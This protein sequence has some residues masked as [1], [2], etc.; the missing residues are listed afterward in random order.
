VSPTNHQTRPAEPSQEF[1]ERLWAISSVKRG[2]APSSL[3]F[4]YGWVWLRHS[5]G[6]ACVVGFSTKVTYLIVPCRRV[7]RGF[8]GP[9]FR[10]RWGW[11]V[12]GQGKAARMRCQAVAIAAAHRQ[13]AS[14]RSR[15]WRA[16]R[17]MRAAVCS[18]R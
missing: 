2:A 1:P 16:P 15:V 12:G 10:G 13:V 7:G 6:L 8:P 14:M 17:V 18:T 11:W 4:A 5:S 3:D 9:C